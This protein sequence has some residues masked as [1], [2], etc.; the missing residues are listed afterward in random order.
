ML[1]FIR[2]TKQQIVWQRIYAQPSVSSSS[3]IRLDET[4]LER[5]IAHYSRRN[6]PARDAILL[7]SRSFVATIK[8]L[9]R[10]ILETTR[11]VESRNNSRQISGASSTGCHGRAARGQ[12]NVLPRWQQLADHI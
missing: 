4:T 12:R 3:E 1:D 9:D 6:D 10:K 8:V 11:Y 2:K 5:A 7:R